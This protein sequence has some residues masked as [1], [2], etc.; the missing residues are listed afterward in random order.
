MRRNNRKYEYND[1]IESFPYKNTSI[2]RTSS[3]PAR[4]RGKKHR[5]ARK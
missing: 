1:I 5:Y 4:V 3:I 2:E